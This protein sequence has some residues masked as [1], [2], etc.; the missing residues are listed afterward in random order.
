MLVPVVPAGKTDPLQAVRTQCRERYPRRL[1]ALTAVVAGAG[2]LLA[3]RDAG[4]CLLYYTLHVAESR[5]LVLVSSEV[6]QGIEARWRLLRKGETVA[7]GPDLVV[8]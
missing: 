7:V 1:S 3:H 5:D 2:G 6:L 4:N 8:T